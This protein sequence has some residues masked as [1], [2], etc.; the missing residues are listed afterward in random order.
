VFYAALPRFFRISCVAGQT[1]NT[2]PAS[3]TV[4]G[5]VPSQI[6]NGMI[7]WTNTNSGLIYYVEQAISTNGPWQSQW[8]GQTNIHTT[9]TVT[10]AFSVPMFFRVVTIVESGE[11]P[12]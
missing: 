2:T 3:Y 1:T 8:A 7:R 5:I 12:W 10:N 9:V 4:T 6:E 11:L